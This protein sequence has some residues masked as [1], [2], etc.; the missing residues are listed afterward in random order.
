M[1]GTREEV[2]DKAPSGKQVGSFWRTELKETQTGL[3]MPSVL[4]G[5]AS[6]RGDAGA[7]CHAGPM[8]TSPAT[9]E[10][11]FQPDL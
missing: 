3:Q 6:C 5:T 8:A 4:P 1:E 7:V 11:D 9:G 2:G 10:W